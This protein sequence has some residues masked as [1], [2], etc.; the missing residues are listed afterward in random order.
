MTLLYCTFTLCLQLDTGTD[1][2]ILRKHL[3][4][5]QHTHY[6]ILFTANSNQV[7]FST[8]QTLHN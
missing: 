7:S 1:T 6:G 8:K 5:L 2:I 3:V 4:T